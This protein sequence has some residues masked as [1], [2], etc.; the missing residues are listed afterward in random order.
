MG[1][2]TNY[3]THHELCKH[4]D[5]DAE[6]YI[7]K[8]IEL[9][10]DFLGFTDHVPSRVFNDR[11]RMDE[12]DFATYLKDLEHNFQRF[13]GHIK[14][15]SGLEAEYNPKDPGEPERWLREVDYLILGQ[16]YTSR[17]P[18]KSGEHYTFDLRKGKSLIT[19][20][21]TVREAIQTNCFS[22]VAHPDIFLGSYPSFD[23]YAANASEIIIDAA[24]EHNVALEFNANGIRR[25]KRKSQ[26]GLHYAYP[27]EPFFRMAQAKGASIVLNSDA[28]DPDQ[29]Y[30]DAMR[31]AE[32]LIED[33]NLKITQYPELK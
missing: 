21:H 33:W 5:G 9:G 23:R 11:A 26:D 29:L 4:A 31:K 17:Y 10:F 20:A 8:A 7:Q 3:H 12:E 28:H 6:A 19:Y 16:H 30:D 25:G 22:I 2:K 15:L 24:V 14:L 18:T 13:K 32:Q 27:R 1:I